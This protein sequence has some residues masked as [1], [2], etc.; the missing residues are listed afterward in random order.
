MAFRRSTVRSRPSP[1][2]FVRKVRFYRTFRHYYA[3]VFIR[4]ENSRTCITTLKKIS[5]SSIKENEGKSIL[6]KLY[7]N[8]FHNLVTSLY[9][10]KAISKDD[11][12]DLRRF[13]DHVEREG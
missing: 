9:N 13:L 6:K 4:W 8:S 5:Q 2:Q 12:T 3:Y 7:G 11:L 10:G 1:P